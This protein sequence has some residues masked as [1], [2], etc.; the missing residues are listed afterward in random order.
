M[1]RSIAPSVSNDP[2]PSGSIPPAAPGI[3]SRF[4]FLFVTA[5]LL[6]VVLSA[7]GSSDSGAGVGADAAPTDP[8]RPADRAEPGSGASDPSPSPADSPPTEPSP[9][10]AVP[11]GTFAVGRT[12]LDLV[13]RSRPTAAHGG[14]PELD[15]RPL[16]TTVWYPAV[17]D[18]PATAPIDGAAPLIVFGHGSTR[19]GEH[20]ETTLRAWASAGYV[21][22]APAFP[23]SKEGTPGGTDY[24][25][26]AE[27]AGDVSFVIDQ[28]LDGAAEVAGV[29]IPL[30]GAVGVGGQSFGAITAIGVATN[31]ATADP[32]ISAFTAFAGMWF[33]LGSG[34]EVAP[35]AENVHGLFV[36]GDAD[37]TVPYDG[38]VRAQELLG[39][40]TRVLT[41]PGGGHDDG[42]FDGV[43]D[44][45]SRVVTEST[46]AFYDRWLKGD[47]DALDRLEAVVEGS[48]GAAV[49]EPDII[50][51]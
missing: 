43:D 24:G 27:Q 25:G 46:L 23:L 29:P 4:R 14:R 34:D 33:D 20:H 10:D 26:I 18:G 22:A 39:D 31:A 13:D 45:L 44:P 3:G 12:E 41:I 50:G 7:C 36:H 48:D 28:V 40:R 8:D 9:A 15:H 5:A 17:A 32:R 2:N 42:F 19:L 6:A 47:V 1:P 35:S 38:A 51:P 49:L 16:P 21:I 11:I 37:P 30:D